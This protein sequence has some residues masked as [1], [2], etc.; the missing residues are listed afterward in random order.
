MP[1][2]IERML[3]KPRKKQQQREPELVHE[4]A[5]IVENYKISKKYHYY[6]ITVE[7]TNQFTKI[8]TNLFKK[9]PRPAYDRIFIGLN[10]QDSKHFSKFTGLVSYTKDE[11]TAN[12][13]ISSSAEGWNL[14]ANGNPDENLKT[15][16][17]NVLQIALS[18]LL[19][20]WKK[21]ESVKKKK[22]RHWK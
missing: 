14:P 1:V 11:K 18:G 15:V 12:E 19:N 5:K 4:V 8:Y 7:C 22:T 16:V 21:E 13:I 10:W 3:S 2:T 6:V 17:R 9:P 20:E